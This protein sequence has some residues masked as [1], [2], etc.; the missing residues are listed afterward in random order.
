MNTLAPAADSQQP[1]CVDADLPVAQGAQTQII[2]VAVMAGAP[3]LLDY[4][5]PAG[6]ECA[7]GMRVQVPLGRRCAIG[8]IVE[9]TETSELAIEALRACQAVLDETPLLEPAL[10]NLL[11][12]TAGYYHHRLGEVMATALPA[13]LRQGKAATVAGISRWRASAAAGDGLA[14][15]ARAPRQRQLLQTLLEQPDGLDA[16]AL[17][18]AFANWRDAMKALVEKGWVVVETRSCL[19]ASPLSPEAGPPLNAAQINAVQQVSANLGRFAPYVLAGIT[20]SGKTEVYLQLARAARAKG[21]QILILV[22]E[23]A[24]TPQ[25]IERFRARLAQPVAVLHSGLSDSQRL[26]AWLGAASG[27]TRVVIGTRSAVFVPLAKPALMVVDEEHD[28]SL[29]QQDGLRY[30]A[31][32]V[33]VKR[34]AELQV[35]IVL[36]SATPS[37]ESLYNVANGHYQR[38][39]LPQRVGN[40]Q[41]P[42]VHV[43]DLRRQRVEHGLSQRLLSL[44]EQHLQA[45][46]QVLICLNRRGYAPVLLCQDCGTAIDCPHCDA[47][48]IL[49]TT[50]QRLHCHHCG[51]QM[52]PPDR[53]GA[54]GSGELGAVGVGTQRLETFLQARFPA[55]GV[56]RIDRDSTQKRGSLETTLR[57]VREG[58]YRLLIG[59][60]MLAKGHDFPAVTLAAVINIDQGLLTAD[61]RGPERTAQLLLQVGGRA[62]RGARSGTMVI[63]TYQPEHPLLTTLLTRGYHAFAEA[64]LNERRAA[65]L[66]PATALAMLRAEAR[67]SQTA[68]AFLQTVATDWRALAK[69]TVQV[70][71]PMPASMQRRAGYYRAQIMLLAPARRPLHQLL[72]AGL[73]R[74]RSYDGVNKVRWH[75]DIDPQEV[76]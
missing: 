22:P 68:L 74:L 40:A 66:P 54:C 65:A 21:G 30:N 37:L 76:L 29:K 62:G 16:T 23:I 51:Q 27:A 43:I 6:I 61:F 15:L 20:G 8:V 57:A 69:D 70:I 39:E 38:L 14:Q 7:P 67:Q 64:A 36:G 13:P 52:R 41:L 25:L 46:G 9:L 45:D 3:G 47:H 2:R 49:H 42:T 32:D 35:P 31:R 1:S 60:Q 18:A 12:W 34:A 53:C 73:P 4:L 17:N 33:A 11:Q 24:L 55:A 19:P 59:T 28:S 63:Q 48:L 75:L 71:G 5:A 58:R 50:D 72:R 56:V 10:L 44:I 26:C